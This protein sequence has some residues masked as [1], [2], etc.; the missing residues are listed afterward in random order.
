MEWIVISIIVTAILWVVLGIDKKS[1]RV[2]KKQFLCLF[3][4][5]ISLGGV[6]CT[7][8][9]GHTGIL[10]TFGKVENITLEAG[11]HAKLPWQ[12]VVCM[13]NRTQKNNVNMSC[14]SSDIQEVNV[15]YSIN[16]QIKKQNAQ[17]IY[18]TIGTEYYNV[19]MAPRI[20]EAVKRVI[21]QYTAESLVEKREELSVKITDILLNDLKDYNINVTSTAIEDLDFSD[22]FTNSV[23]EKVVAEQA[24][25][26]AKTEQQQK[27]MEEQQSAE[28]RQIAAKAAAEV[29]KIQ[30]NAE[31]EVLQIQAD[32]AEYAGQKDAAINKALS[33]SLTPT[34]LEYYKIKQWNGILPSYFVSGS[35]AVLPILGE[36]PTGEATPDGGA[37]AGE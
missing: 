6:L 32:A 27:T 29:S 7:V 12:E 21:A 2:N 26:K 35:G 16:Y 22:A 11:V 3:A 34:L 10:T 23:E 37:E 25:L 5:L 4:L 30:A 18:A 1:W 17:E 24:Y 19:I 36:L 20:H 8:P 33:E 31:K 15:V 9:T 13:D 14:F 28:R